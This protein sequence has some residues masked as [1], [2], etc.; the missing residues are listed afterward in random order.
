MNTKVVK[1]TRAVKKDK[2]CLSHINFKNVTKEKFGC[3][4]RH[5]EF[6]SIQANDG[7]REEYKY[8][9]ERSDKLYNFYYRV[10]NGVPGDVRDSYIKGVIELKLDNEIQINRWWGKVSE[11][12]KLPWG[13]KFNPFVNKFY[14]HITDDNN[15]SSKDSVWQKQ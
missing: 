5:E 1:K 4:F 8:L 12:Y 2:D 13:T 10:P 3:G 15:V 7:E 6:P 11:K 9:L 14:R